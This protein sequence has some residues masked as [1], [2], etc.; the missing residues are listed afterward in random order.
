M[1]Y[2][3]NSY[4]FAVKSRELHDECITAGVNM[5]NGAY[6]TWLQFLM[7]VATNGDSENDLLV[8]FERWHTPS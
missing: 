8:F 5:H 1:Q 2:G 7:T 3:S 4:G 6:V